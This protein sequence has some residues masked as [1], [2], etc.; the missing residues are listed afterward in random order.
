M[1]EAAIDATLVCRF[2]DL[3]DVARDARA[4]RRRGRGDHRRADR[5]QLAGPAPA[6]GLPRRPA[7]RCATATGALLIFDEVITGFRHHTRRLPGDLRR[8]A[9]PD[10]DGQGDRQRLPARRGRRRAR[11]HLER[12]TTNPD[13]DVHFGG[14]YNGNAVA[15]EAGARDDRAARGRPRARA[16]L[17][18]RRADARRARDDRR[19]APGSRRSSAA[20]ARCS[21]SAS[22]T[23]R[24]T[25]YEDVLRN[26]TEL[27]VRY[28]RELIARGVFEMP[29]S[30]GPQPHQR[31]AHR[32]RRRPLARG[33]RGGAARRARPRARADQAAA[34]AKA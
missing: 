18:A 30:L 6:P 4:P 12:F 25:S 13:G 2:N 1:L 8:H 29:E 17:R 26:D 5:A 14:T 16:R 10:D 32:R 27:F 15:V 33:R 19:R 21:C 28:R 11:E 7:R 3:D 23:A 31:G 34:G 24:S 9:G 22:W 20:S